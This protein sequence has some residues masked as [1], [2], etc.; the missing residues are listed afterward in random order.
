MQVQHRLPKV[1]GINMRMAFDMH[2]M[3]TSW[4][5]HRHHNIEHA[6]R[7]DDPTNRTKAWLCA[8]ISSMA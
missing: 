3:L 4:R 5:D 6:W 2:V 8:W 1:A 7:D